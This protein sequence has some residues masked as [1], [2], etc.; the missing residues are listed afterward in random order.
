LPVD[1]PNISL[2]CIE[3]ESKQR[4]MERSQKSEVAIK[5]ATENTER[6]QTYK[7]EQ[8]RSGKLIG[9]SRRTLAC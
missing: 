3:K 4:E 1:W 5:G 7:E 6:T 2:G 8:L 9:V